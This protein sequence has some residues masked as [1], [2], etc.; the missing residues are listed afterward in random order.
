MSIGKNSLVLA[1]AC[2]IYV[3]GN[4]KF[5]YFLICRN[6]ALTL[7]LLKAGL[8]LDPVALK[9][10]SF[11][12]LRLAFTPCIGETAAVAVASHL[13]LGLPWTWG[14]MLG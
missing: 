11:T 1:W 9:K 3:I 5:I 4:N 2:C 12:V 13:L 7:I 14:I 8:G 6:A 10:L